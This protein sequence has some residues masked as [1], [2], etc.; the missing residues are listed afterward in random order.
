MAQN[1]DSAPQV[2][3]SERRPEELARSVWEEV[4]VSDEVVSPVSLNRGGDALPLIE[5]W[6]TANP[7]EA[8]LATGFR[9]GRQVLQGISYGHSYWQM[10]NG[11][12]LQL[13]DEAMAGKHDGV[14]LG[15]E[16]LLQLVILSRAP[17]SPPEME[18]DNWYL[19]TFRDIDHVKQEIREKLGIAEEHKR[20]WE[21]ENP[22][23]YPPEFP[24]VDD[25]AIVDAIVSGKLTIGNPDE[26]DAQCWRETPTPV[27]APPALSIK[28]LISHIKHS[29]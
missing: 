5:S 9:R 23:T 8:A 20:I 10:E 16:R 26:P 14:K 4:R 7:K 12:D 21:S 3:T 13:D 29:K 18:S 28:R 22:P 11:L 6:Q 17:L 24:G 1:H 27:E 19:P 25:T 2:E 15:T